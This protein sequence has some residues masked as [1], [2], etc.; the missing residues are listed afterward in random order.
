MKIIAVGSPK[1][2]VGKTTAAVHLAHSLSSHG[3][4]LLVDADSIQSAAGWAGDWPNVDVTSTIGADAQELARLRQADYAYAVVDL[5]GA[6]DAESWH[7]LLAPPGERPVPDLLLIPSR[8]R[9]IDLE[10][11]VQLIRQ[12]IAGRLPYLIVFTMVKTAQ[13]HLAEQRAN[14]LRGL[15]LLV[16]SH[17]IRDYSVY[18]EAQERRSPVHRIGGERHRTARDAANDFEGLTSEV[19]TLTQ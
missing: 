12:E 4:T 13:M 8:P 9:L 7:A 5:P 15:D 10:P 1:G 19:R 3:R 11:A 18:D 6:R 16:S 17:M 14:E 2:G